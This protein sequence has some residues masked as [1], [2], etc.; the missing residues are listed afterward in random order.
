RSVRADLVQGADDQT[1]HFVPAYVS[2]L[3]LSIEENRITGLSAITRVTLQMT[4]DQVPTWA[5]TTARG[6][7]LQKLPDGWEIKRLR[8]RTVKLTQELLRN[9]GWRFDHL[10]Q[11]IRTG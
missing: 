6:F 8:K 7:K 3:M 9:R 5:V 1:G 11:L 4:G 2:C 10:R